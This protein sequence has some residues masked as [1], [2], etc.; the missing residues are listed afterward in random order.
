MSGY[1]GDEA[2]TGRVLVPSPLPGPFAERVCRTGDLVT[3]DGDG[4]YLYIGRR[5]HM[6][7]IRGYRVELGEVE[8]ALYEHEG[9][10]EAA[11]YVVPDSEGANHLFASVVMSDGKAMTPK[12][13]Q[14]FCAARLPKYMVPEEIGIER[15]LP[16][17]S[18][19]KVDR[20]AL[21]AAQR[22]DAAPAAR[23]A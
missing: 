12:D 23:P 14:T 4:Q 20:P 1:W 19:G 3:I 22:G 13:L 2:K 21:V 16:K 15:A 8:T 5:D 7:K 11:A 17:T 10:H 18:T 6:V 9:V